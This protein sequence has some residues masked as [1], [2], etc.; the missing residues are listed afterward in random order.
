VIPRMPVMVFAM[1]AN[2]LIDYVRAA[3]GLTGVAPATL[4][5]G[6]RG[7]LGQISRLE[8]G[9]RRYAVKELF[10]N[11]APA[12][13]IIAA[14]VDFTARAAE[15]G[16]HVAASYPA[17]DGRYVV[18]MPDGSGWLRLY[19]WLD[20]RPL[21]LNADGLPAQLGTLLGRLHGCAPASDREPDGTPPDTWFDVP[22]ADD[23]WRSL[24]DAAFT[25]NA[26]WARDLASRL[27]LIEAITTLAVPA[28]TAAMVTCHRDLHPDNVL[29]IDGGTGK[30][31]QLA[32]IDW[33]DLGPA[34]PS[35]ELVRVLLD[36]FF[37]NDTLNTEAVRGMLSAYRATGAPGRISEDT[38]G[39]AIAS[40]LNFLYRQVGI[41]LDSTAQARHR[42]W[43]IS[44]IEEALR[45]LPTPTVLAHLTA[46]DSAVA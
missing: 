2:D 15:A 13:A 9:C 27:P 14:E 41:A 8:I 21:D 25:A 20:A 3:F 16:V 35:R 43:A 1:S 17:T 37:D 7:A 5:P 44:E 38:F 28:D 40:R 22:P 10:N 6:G 4:T 42:E 26:T 23:G 18:P 24:L 32:V 12:A 45:I 34:D 29:V 36:W 30:P 19:D 46:L 33:D 31:G 11:D 39:F